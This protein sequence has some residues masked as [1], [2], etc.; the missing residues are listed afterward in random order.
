MRMRVSLKRVFW[1]ALAA[2]VAV[3]C[4]KSKDK[5]KP[6]PVAE[7]KK[8]FGFN[9]AP[10]DGRPV[11]RAVY[12]GTSNVDFTK[13]HPMTV[14]FYGLPSNTAIQ[15]LNTPADV[16]TLFKFTN[17]QESVSE[18]NLITFVKR[19]CTDE[20]LGTIQNCLNTA[21]KQSGAIVFLPKVKLTVT[22]DPNDPNLIRD[23][24]RNSLGMTSVNV[25]T[26]TGPKPHYMISCAN[27]HV[28]A[29]SATN[30]AGGKMLTMNLAGESNVADPLRTG[31]AQT[32]I[33]K[34]KV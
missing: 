28:S 10:S 1:I 27:C 32:Y 19:A 23:V 13:L 14:D 2:G 20:G 8:V 22:T 24:V 16:D 34:A 25:D 12:A 18:E 30:E 6:A 21:I 17:V 31:T 5:E 33:D 15:I 11:Q 3:G 9:D 7:T 26:P 4:S 29:I